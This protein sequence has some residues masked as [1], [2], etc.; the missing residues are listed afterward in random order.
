MTLLD[1][2][3]GGAARALQLLILTATRS[4]EV[5]G[6]RWSE[7]DLEEKIWTIPAERMK[8]GVE[9]RVPL[10]DQVLNILQRVPRLESVD[11]LFPDRSGRKPISDLA[12]SK[13]LRKQQLGYV[14]HGFR[15][16][17][18]DWAGDHTEY[19]RELLEAS[20]AHT[21]ESKV[22]AAYQRKDALERRRPLMQ[23]WADFIAQR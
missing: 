6:A 1:G 11:M 4:G 7:F 23:D 16:T 21:L 22:E 8:A 17:F 9:H 15:S 19:A 2:M 20:L 18:R 10:S 14:P 13:I 3:E 12:L 5:R